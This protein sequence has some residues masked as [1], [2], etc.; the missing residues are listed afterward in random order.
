MPG[1]SHYKLWL[2]YL[3]AVVSVSLL[4]GLEEQLNG[5]LQSPRSNEVGRW[6][7]P[8]LVHNEE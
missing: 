8:G 1:S 3:D 5:S 2:W 6:N 7:T 4:Q